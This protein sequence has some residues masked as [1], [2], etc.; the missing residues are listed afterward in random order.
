MPGGLFF[1]NYSCQHRQNYSGALCIT[2]HTVVVLGV[3]VYYLDKNYMKLGEDYMKYEWLDE[4]LLSKP[5]VVKDYKIEWDWHRYIVGSK[6][7]AATMC[8]SDKHN[9]MYAGKE[10]INLKSEPMLSEILRENHPQYILP[11]FYSDKLSWN[12]IDLGGDVPDDKL[13]QII[14]D[15][16]RLVFAKLTKKLQKDISGETK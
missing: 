8:P 2:R 9:P 1:Y 12:S 11:G 4:Y 15:S 14:D 3:V 10:L 16:Y 7:F 5:G 13:K 6:M